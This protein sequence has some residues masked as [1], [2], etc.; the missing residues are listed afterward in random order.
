VLRR[1]QDDVTQAREQLGATLDEIER[2]LM[3]GNVGKVASWWLKRQSRKHP[4][5]FAI[6]GVA[7]GGLVIG[8]LSWAAVSQDE[9]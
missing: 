6:G 8:L 4:I 5:P 7:L 2:R 1:E 3:P 9:D